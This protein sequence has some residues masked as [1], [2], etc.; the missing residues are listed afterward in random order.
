ME[1]LDFALKAYLD[2]SPVNYLQRTHDARIY[3]LTFDGQTLVVGSESWVATNPV[4]PGAEQRYAPVFSRY[5]A[6]FKRVENL[7]I[8]VFENSRPTLEDFKQFEI[9]KVTIAL[10]AVSIETDE[11]ELRF[12]CKTFDLERFPPAVD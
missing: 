8:F 4:V 12:T 10:P 3:D 2:L 6:T 7:Q 11:H 9:R 1:P 5:R